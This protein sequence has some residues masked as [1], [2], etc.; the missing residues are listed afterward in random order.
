MDEQDFI[1]TMTVL[2]AQRLTELYSTSMEAVDWRATRL[3]IASG[4]V[5]S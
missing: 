1:S 5:A 2:D 3:F 4:D